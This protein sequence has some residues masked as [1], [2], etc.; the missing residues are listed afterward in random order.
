MADGRTGV[1]REGEI[2]IPLPGRFYFPTGA[3]RARDSLRMLLEHPYEK[4]CF[5]HGSPVLDRP[6]EALERFIADEEYWD[7]VGM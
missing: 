4:M 2:R 6:K 5:A 3:Q 1:S 7:M